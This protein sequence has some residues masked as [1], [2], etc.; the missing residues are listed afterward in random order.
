MDGNYFFSSSSISSLIL[1][2]FLIRSRSS[3]SSTSFSCFSRHDPFTLFSQL[4]LQPFILPF[5]NTQLPPLLVVFFSQTAYCFHLQSLSQVFLFVFI[6]TFLCVPLSP[7]LL[8]LFHSLFHV[9]FISSQ[10]PSNLS[11]RIFSLSLS[12]SSNLFTCAFTSS[13][14]VAFT[15]GFSLSLLQLPHPPLQLFIL[16]FPLISL[17]FCPLGKRRNVAHG[18]YCKT[19]TSQPKLSIYLLQ[20]TFEPRNSDLHHVAT[21]VK[22]AAG[23]EEEFVNL[24]EATTSDNAKIHGVVQSLSPMKRGKSSHYF[25]GKISDGESH[26]RVV[27]F[28][29][30]LRKHIPKHIFPGFPCAL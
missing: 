10:N 23:S 14:S 16:L 15:S 6:G 29:D 11:F 13:L 17:S 7:S 3:T 26:M 5:K 30:S 24:N 25:K 19:H 28:Q 9:V 21:N 2:S 27:G 1:T 12:L 20:L 8:Q 22:T 4:L 18:L